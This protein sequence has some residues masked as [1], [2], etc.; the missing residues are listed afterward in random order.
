MAGHDTSDTAPS[1]TRAALPPSPCV[2]ICTL[3]GDHCYGCGRTSD[4]I[5]HWGTLSPS[6]QSAVWAQL[7]GRLAAF[8]FKTFRLAAGPEVVADFISRT[9]TESTGA[10]R[11]VSTSIEA[12]F[13][14][15]RDAPAAVDETDMMVTATAGDGASVSLIKHPKVRVFGFASSAEMPALDTV[16]L[17]LPKGR[18]ERDL[19]RIDEP[20]DG[21][22]S[23]HLQDRYAKAWIEA[24]LGDAALKAAADT[25]LPHDELA[26][27]AADG[28][29]RVILRNALGSVET[30]HVT[31]AASAPANDANA[32]SDMR[33]SRAFVAAAV[34][35]ADN[36]E[37]LA[38][39]LAP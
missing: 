16:A 4:E 15:R 12:R 23:L 8:G 10:W 38:A 18:A 33:I 20:G 14:I 26:L 25:P 7:P 3:N 5:A 2:G 24:P 34:F 19:A 36:P 27:L 13:E 11:L 29:R 32:P 9:F 6:A 37:W 17:V 39:A 30:P 22:L 1:R 31:V 35:K 21:F 28:D